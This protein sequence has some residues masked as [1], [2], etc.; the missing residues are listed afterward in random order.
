[1]DLVRSLPGM[2]SFMGASLPWRGAR[3]CCGAWCLHQA[4]L[5]DALH[6]A[7]ERFLAPWHLGQAQGA[8]AVEPVRFGE[9]QELRAHA[10]F[11]FP[12]L[13]QP[14][15]IGLGAA[16]WLVEPFEVR[17]P[18]GLRFQ[19]GFFWPILHDGLLSSKTFTVF[20]PGFFLR[21]VCR[22][23]APL[24]SLATSSRSTPPALFGCC[25]ICVFLPPAPLPPI[26]PCRATSRR[27][28]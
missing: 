28:P 1:M 9:L 26:P 21:A 25:G 10:G 6:G 8:R 15:Q 4:L 7:V 3:P 14:C 17:P 16:A 20:F 22:S 5:D 27:R 2:M 23:L 12:E 24:G 18:L 13:A 19:V 11:V